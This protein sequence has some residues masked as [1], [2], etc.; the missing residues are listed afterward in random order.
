ME[1]QVSPAI[2]AFIEHYKQEHIKDAYT[3]LREETVRLLKLLLKQN[4]IMAIVSARVK[5]PERLEAK[6]QKLEQARIDEGKG[7][8]RDSGEI[9]ADMHD[10]VGARVAL[11][12]PSDA[13]RVGELLAPHFD[14]VGGSVFPPKVDQHEE[15]A[16]SGYT[17]HKRRIYPGYENR[18]FDGYCA[19]HH[20]VRLAVNPVPE[21]PDTVIEIQVASV[22]M[23]AWSEVEHDLAYKKLMGTVTEAEYACLD[24]INGLVMAGEIALNRLHQLSQQRIQSIST[25]DSQ[26][27]LAAYLSYWQEQHSWGNLSLGNVA[28][29][30]QSYRDAGCL[31]AVYLLQQLQR[32]VDL[33]WW[34]SDTPLADQ[35]IDLFNN[36][37]HRKIVTNLVSQGVRAVNENNAEAPSDGQIRRFQQRWNRLEDLTRKAL[38]SLG[39]STDNRTNKLLSIEMDYVLGRE[40]AA[41]YNRLRCLR[42]QVVYKY[43]APSRREMEELIADTDQLAELLKREY[44]V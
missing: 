10:L 7:P 2:A 43:L 6:L 26:Y 3:Q 35:L 1:G 31:T 42:N 27:A 17:A 24:E 11:Y 38:R 32:L 25:F 41:E 44:G 23:H 9:M 37:G 14:R 29:L 16:Q 36:Q 39:E 20:H 22:L 4:G 18:R 34:E 13:A 5:A 40:F 15:L 8:Y 12:F 28:L 30:F 19:I 21:L 33:H